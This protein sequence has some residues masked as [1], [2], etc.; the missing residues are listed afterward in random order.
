MDIIT[1]NIYDDITELSDLNLQKKLWLN[2]NN[3]TGLISS[4]VEVMCRLFDDNGFDDFIDNRASK[5]GLSNSVIFELS[6]LR[7]LLK[8]YDEKDLDEEIIGDPEWGN[9]VEQAKTVIR[10]WDKM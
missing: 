8:N 5:T 7:G 3:D 1:K 4:Y 10:E 9:I 2:K 6:K